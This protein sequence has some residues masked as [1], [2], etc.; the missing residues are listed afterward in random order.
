VITAVDTSVLLDVLANDARFG[1]ASLHA[2]ENA[3]EAGRLVVCPIVWAELRAFFD[4]D[5]SLGDALA[6]AGIFFD[7]FDEAAASLAGA[8]WRSY[9]R[10]G[11]R[12]TRLVGDFLI[13]AHA[14][15]RAARLLT[16]DRGFYRRYFESLPI[17]EPAPPTA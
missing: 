17:I 7:P 4:G 12:R 1:T 2:L 16:R 15:T 13:G 11:G 9:R 10:S 6:E 14:Q 5:R 3:H 8:Q